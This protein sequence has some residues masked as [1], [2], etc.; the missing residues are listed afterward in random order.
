MIIEYELWHWRVTMKRLMVG[1]V[2][3]LVSGPMLYHVRAQEQEFVV[4]VHG[5]IL[6]PLGQFGEKIGSSPQITN[7]FGFDYGEKVG[8]ATTGFGGGIE[9][10]TLIQGKHLSW[11]ISGKFLSSSTDD[12]KIYQEFKHEFGDSLDVT[13]ANGSW[14]NIPFFT[15]FK[16]DYELTQGASLYGLIQGGV[17]ITQQASRK[18]SVGITVIE[19]TTFKFMADF[20]FEVGFGVELF[21]RINLS[22]RYIN[23]GSP[24]YEGTRK[25]NVS[26]FPTIP[27]R[28]MTIDG[29]ERPVSM[30]LFMV[31]YVL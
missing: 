7:R 8:L 31:G 12:S 25:L 20:G 11:I 15:G 21:K 2:M 14:T 9:A 26:Y 6:V 4:T 1:L 24:R 17:N 28:E 29:D 3:C 13:F 10:S 19:E 27:R 16:Y 5:N 23:L 18:A 30:L 22:A